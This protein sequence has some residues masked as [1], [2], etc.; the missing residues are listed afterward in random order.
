M[1]YLVIIDVYGTGRLNNQPRYTQFL[2]YNY[3]PNW[4]YT[5][6]VDRA[7]GVMWR[8]YTYSGH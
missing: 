5:R 4:D 8:I 7:H 1:L 3:A 6:E 2:P